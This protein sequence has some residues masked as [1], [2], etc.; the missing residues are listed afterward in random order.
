MTRAEKTDAIMSEYL[1]AYPIYQSQNLG[2]NVSEMLAKMRASSDKATI[3]IDLA[4]QTVSGSPTDATD[5]TKFDA[6]HG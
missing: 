2:V 3:N 6:P 5:F 4:D 1:N